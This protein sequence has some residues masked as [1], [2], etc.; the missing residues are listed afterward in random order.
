VQRYRFVKPGD[1]SDSHWVFYWNYALPF[2]GEDQLSAVQAVH[3]QHSTL[4]PSVTIKV[5]APA[6]DTAPAEEILEFVDHVDTALQKHVG[7]NAVPGTRRLP[8][9]LFR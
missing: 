4:P 2:A 3:R 5:F 7:P 8:M 6:R 9:A 1:P